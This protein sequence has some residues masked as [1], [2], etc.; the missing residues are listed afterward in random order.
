MLPNLRSVDLRNSENLT[1]MTN[2][3]KMPNLVMLNLE[4]C[5]G[6]L[7]LDPSI[8]TLRKLKY[9]NLKNCI[10][11]ISIPN[12]LFAVSS[13][14]FLNLAG[15]SRLAKRLDFDSWRSSLEVKVLSNE[16][17]T[18]LELQRRDLLRLFHRLDREVIYAIVEEAFI[19]VRNKLPRSLVGMQSRVE[20]LE[21]LIDLGSH[22]IVRVVGICG[23]VGVGKTTLGRVVH[24]RIFYHFE[25]G[26]FI[27]IVKELDKMLPNL[28][29]V[30]LRNSKD[31]RTIS[32]ISM[33]PNLERLNL[34]GCTNLRQLHPSIATLSK[35]KFLNLK[36]CTNLVS[37]PNKLFGS[38]SLGFLNLA[39]C[40]R[41]GECLDFDSWR[42]SLE[43]KVLGR[44]DGTL[45]ELRVWTMIDVVSCDHRKQKV[46]WIGTLNK[47][48]WEGEMGDRDGGSGG[49]SG[50]GTTEDILDL[51]W[52]VEAFK[53]ANGC[54]LV[55][56]LFAEKQ[57]NKNTAFS[58]IKKG[59]N[60]KD[61]VSIMEVGTNL[62]LFSFANEDDYR[63][64]LKGRPWTILGSLLNIQR[65]SSRSII[66]EICFNRAP[67][68]VQF[69][70]LPLGVLCRDNVERMGAKV[71]D[72][73]VY[74]NPIF[75]GRL[76]RSFARARVLIDIR[77]PLVAG[78]WVP[79]PGLAKVWVSVRY[80][81]L[82]HF[83][84]NCGRIG[85]KAKSCKSRERALSLDGKPLF[86]PWIGTAPVRAWE[87]ALVICRDDWRSEE[88]WEPE[89]AREE[90]SKDE[91]RVEVD[92]NHNSVSP[93]GFRKPR[94]DPT[95]LGQK[96]MDWVGPEVSR[97]PRTQIA[98]KGKSEG[99]DAMHLDGAE[100]SCV[101]GGL[102]LN[103][104]PNFRAKRNRGKA[105]AE[106]GPTN[107]HPL[108][109]SGLTVN[110][111]T[112]S[113]YIVE[114]PSDDDLGT[115]SALVPFSCG[116]MDPD[117]LMNLGRVSLKRAGEEVTSPL[118]LKKR[119]VV[120]R[121]ISSKASVSFVFDPEAEGVE[122]GF[123][124]GKTLAKKG[125]GKRK[126]KP[127]SLDAGL[128]DVPI[129]SD[130]CFPKDWFRFG[131]GHAV[132]GC[133]VRSSDGS[134]GWPSAATKGP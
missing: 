98:A 55:G 37:I 82:N 65:C 13:L 64:I 127:V 100:S 9:L 68:W 75:N 106:D 22:N 80:E 58:M 123:S 14:N 46:V 120:E 126:E 92:G 35:L 131:E 77:S 122:K 11:L 103:S 18:L 7:Q 59:W 38:S 15:C 54:S 4:G 81:K 76:I 95:P 16:E 10:N 67:F 45:L 125:K 5:T 97:I 118:K 20:A 61:E 130:V 66:K 85:H 93:N 25:A 84:F 74:E 41:L 90:G 107:V 91:A 69:H 70:D 105:G 17:A 133:E 71:G 50:R 57:I 116:N 49:G 99:C 78:F 29:S 94:E 53:C 112:P 12:S 31:I 26:G 119:K 27:T 32:D 110:R 111:F 113:R 48:T 102:T 43:E 28:R 8:A 34:E 72:V 129:E 60:L 132:A 87:E 33:M 24:D 2:F 124:P 73:M 56:R 30:D 86:G 83:C 23:M 19:K 104:R 79:R 1:T 108:D 21:N 47:L 128:V 51:R 62:F 36:N 39:G 42:S 40:S 52:E 63:R 3:R 121:K 115:D 88:Q 134:G 117:V 44:E 89:V 109:S 101:G 114:L 96:G 6:L